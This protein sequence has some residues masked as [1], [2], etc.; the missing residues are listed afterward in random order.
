M[1]QALQPTDLQSHLAYAVYIQQLAREQNEFIHKLIMSN[2]AY[3][4][5][6]G[7]VNKQN[8]KIWAI[9]NPRTVH[10]HELHPIKCTVWCGVTLKSVIEPYFF[11]DKE[12]VTVTVTAQCYQ[13]MIKNCLRPAIQDN[14]EMWFQQ[15]EQLPTLPVKIWCS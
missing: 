14:L 8:C 12:G 4:H 15:D 2:E 1:V 3:F 11:K 10:Q 7:F 9:E 5:L 13:Q 6:N